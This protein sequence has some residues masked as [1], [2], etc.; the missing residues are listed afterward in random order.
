MTKIAL[1]A[2]I[3]YPPLPVIFCYPNF[4]TVQLQDV[5]IAI[6][7]II[8]NVKNKRELYKINKNITIK[9]V[10][11]RHHTVAATNM[12]IMTDHFKS[13]YTVRVV[14]LQTLTL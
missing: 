8:N 14:Q 4:L 3:V 5:D 6:S 7:N 1:F 10:C 9:D 2:V 12:A 13:G 11:F